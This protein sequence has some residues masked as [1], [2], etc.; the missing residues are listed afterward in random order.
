MDMLDVASTGMYAIGLLA[1]IVK[2][3]W[4]TCKK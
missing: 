3:K 1:L 4:Y 2:F